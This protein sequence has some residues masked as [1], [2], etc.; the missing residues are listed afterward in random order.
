[1]FD[2]ILLLLS[3]LATL[4]RIFFLDLETSALIKVDKLFGKTLRL[5]YLVELYIINYS[6]LARL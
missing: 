1:M 2:I 3:P 5:N 6:E 4:S